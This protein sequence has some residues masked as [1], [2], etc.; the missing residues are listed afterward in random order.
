MSPTAVETW[1]SAVS[2]PRRPRSAQDQVCLLQ[3]EAREVQVLADR[4][5]R[6]LCSLRPVVEEEAA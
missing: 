1:A 3:A 2:F 6:A 5:M 4:S